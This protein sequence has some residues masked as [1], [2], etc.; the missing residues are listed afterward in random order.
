MGDLTE[1]RWKERKV[2][3]LTGGSV[4]TTT[5]TT[6]ASSTDPTQFILVSTTPGAFGEFET[7]FGEFNGLKR[8]AERIVEKE[9]P[10]L[11]YSIL[12]MGLYDERMGEGMEIFHEVVSED[13]DA[14]S[15]DSDDDNTQGSGYSIWNEVKQKRINRRDAARAVVEALLDDDLVN[16]KVQCYTTIR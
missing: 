4:P 13:D 7:P 12:Q 3:E 8:Q 11:S 6:S 9:F 1:R 10:S 5:S 2:A 15:A 16:M 14:N